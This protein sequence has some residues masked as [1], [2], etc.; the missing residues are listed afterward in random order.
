MDEAAFRKA[1]QAD[2]MAHDKLL[3]GIADFS[4]ALVTLEEL[5]DKRLQGAAKQ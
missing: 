1:H 2:R 3:Q 4:K 5:L